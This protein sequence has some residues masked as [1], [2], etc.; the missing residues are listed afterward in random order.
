M[1]CKSSSEFW[2][3]TANHLDGGVF[4]TGAYKTETFTFATSKAVTPHW[5]QI[6]L[7]GILGML[8]YR[9]RYIVVDSVQQIGWSASPFSSPSQRAK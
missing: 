9:T 3:S 2:P 5:H 6:F 1:G 7:R 4:E 8:F